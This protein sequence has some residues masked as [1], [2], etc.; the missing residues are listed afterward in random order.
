LFGS[1]DE[2]YSQKASTCVKKAN[3]GVAGY[4]SQNKE[5]TLSRVL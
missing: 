5:P 3:S 2:Y 4:T 1:H